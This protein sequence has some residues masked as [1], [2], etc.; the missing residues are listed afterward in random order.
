M[1]LASAIRTRREVMGRLLGCRGLTALELLVVGCVAIV[2]LLGM[3]AV[4]AQ[5]GQQ[6]WAHIDGRSATMTITQRAMNR[7]SEELRRARQPTV[8]CPQA[9]RLSFIRSDTGANVQYWCE[10]CDETGSGMLIRSEGGVPQVVVSGLASLTLSCPPPSDG[11]MRV[12][13]TAKTGTAPGKSASVLESRV[14]VRNPNP[15]PS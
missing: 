12:R 3:S 7:L 11:M 1:I 6:V 2:I 15:P 10:G 8:S 5:S 13:L 14:W 9:N 4:I